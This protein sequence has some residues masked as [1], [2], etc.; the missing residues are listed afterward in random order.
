MSPRAQSP[1]VYVW[2]LD[3]FVQ[4][5]CTL[6]LL[7]S[8]SPSGHPCPVLRKSIFLSHYQPIEE[9]LSWPQNHSVYHLAFLLSWNQLLHR[10]WLSR[11]MALI[12]AVI[13]FKKGSVDASIH[14][15]LPG[16]K[17]CCPHKISANNY[18]CMTPIRASPT[19]TSS[20]S[21][22]CQYINLCT[23]MNEWFFNIW[24]SVTVVLLNWKN[25]LESTHTIQYSSPSSETHH[26]SWWC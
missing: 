25:E 13:Q 12:C 8:C 20:S 11:E 16:N 17:S 15:D 5:F 26:V 19:H 23:H 3:V 24:W 14:L 4:V 1:L 7:T 21:V 18:Q 10:V 2:S 6:H 22:H 9:E